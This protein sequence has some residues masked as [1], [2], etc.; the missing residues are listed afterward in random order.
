M[1]DGKSSR[2]PAC[3]I[4]ANVFCY[5][6]EFDVR[7]EY[8][9]EFEAAY[10]PA[11]DWARLFRRDPGYLRTD[12]LRNRADLTR[13]L[14]VDFWITREACEAFRARHASEF[15]V[16]DEKC[17]RLTVSERHLGDFEVLE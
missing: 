7:P 10:G 5:I 14:T 11:G 3:A 6:W 15:R 4:P 8:Q 9:A 2:I 16:L 17:E 12:L 1:I 13:F